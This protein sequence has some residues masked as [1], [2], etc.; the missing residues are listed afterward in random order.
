MRSD[1]LCTTKLRKTCYSSDM[2]TAPAAP[3]LDEQICFA[4]YSASR[5]LTTH[6][7]ELLAPLGL[8][9]PQYLVMLVLWQHDGISV[10]ELGERLHLD[11]GTLSPLLR[12]LE[13]GGRLTRVRSA[14]DERVV[15]VSLTADGSRMRDEAA[16]I[17]VG[18]CSA[19]GLDPAAIRSLQEQISALADSVRAFN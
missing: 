1:R 18:V 14:G 2:A 6:Y 19:T 9:Y 8:T 17:P 12:R 15:E 3:L 4:L 11:S 10:S 7:R 13:S 5:A 16:S